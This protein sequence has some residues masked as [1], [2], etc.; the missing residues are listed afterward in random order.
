MLPWVGTTTGKG[1][2]GCGMN[3]NKLRGEKATII[4]PNNLL[5][6]DDGSIHECNT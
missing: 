4:D 1:M 6:R 5:Y 3:Q 2:V